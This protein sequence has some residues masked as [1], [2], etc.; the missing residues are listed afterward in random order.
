MYIAGTTN[1]SNYPSTTG[2]YDRTHN[3]S[4]DIF[5]SRLDSSL[6]SLQISTFIGGTGSDHVSYGDLHLDSSGNIYV[7]GTT[8]STDFPT[9]SGA[10]DTTHNG[11]SDVFVSKLS[12][13]L[14]LTQ[15]YVDIRRPDDSGDGTSWA[16]AWKTLHY[17]IKQINAA[18]PDH[19]LLNVA[20]GI[21]NIANG[22]ADATLVLNQDN[23]TIQGAGA[24]NTIMDGSGNLASW[25]TG[26]E[27]AASDVTVKELSVK[28]FRYKN[29][30]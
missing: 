3:G 21:Y 13:D 25:L 15:Y 1:S 18:G 17:A 4:N 10:S 11:G 24:G 5:I 7:T 22:E 8:G 2:A 27:I 30:F 23:V 9:T 28:E 12:N 16:T 19:Y 20:A 14:S 26:I 6:A 29:I